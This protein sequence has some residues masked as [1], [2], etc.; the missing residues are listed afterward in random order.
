MKN[1]EF[2]GMPWDQRLARILVRPLVGTPVTPNHVTALSFLLGLAA[3]GLYALG[4]GAAHWGGA[5]FMLSVLVD[6]A[7]G[8][9]A[10]MS[11]RSSAFGHY[12]DYITDGLNHI[13]LFVGIG[14]GLRA[15][16]L[17][18]W[19]LPMG[20]AAGL[21]VGFIFSVRLEIERRL[22]K[23]PIAQPHWGGFDIEDAMYL[24]GPVTWMGGLAPFLALASVGAPIY[25][26]WQLW[27]IRRSLRPGQDE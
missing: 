6:H 18:G 3:F 13:L 8:E 25:M 15:G 1:S 21:A 24:V 23:E 14:L 7:D 10:R 27:D 5:L 2:E 12:F 22:G 11:G 4:G 26:I 17:G 9:L 20:V 19:A 16:V